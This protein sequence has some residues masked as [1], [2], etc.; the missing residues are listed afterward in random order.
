[1]A[2]LEV[3]LCQLEVLLGDDLVE[4]VGT[5]AQGLA[6]VAMTVVSCRLASRVLGTDNRGV[7][8][9]HRM[10]SAE[11]SSTLHWVSPQWHFPL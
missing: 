6:G 8:A 5:T 9:Y 10:C 4:G 7:V 11:G 2:Y 3:T 1:M